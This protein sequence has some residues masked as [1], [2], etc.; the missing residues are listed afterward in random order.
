MLEKLAILIYENCFKQAI[1][2]SNT[3]ETNTEQDKNYFMFS[4]SSV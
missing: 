1:I 2:G 4:N 3:R